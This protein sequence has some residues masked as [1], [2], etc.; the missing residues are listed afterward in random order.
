[1]GRIRGLDESA[2]HWAGLTGRAAAHRAAVSERHGHGTVLVLRA[3]GAAVLALALVFPWGPVAEADPPADPPTA[4]DAQAAR[5]AVDAGTLDV[6]QAESALEALRAELAAAQV[7][8][9][10]AAADYAEA[11]LAVE[12]AEREV[13][14]ARSVVEKAR[15][16]EAAARTSLAEVYR[17]SARDADLGPLGVALEADSVPDM[18]GR[19][20]AERAVQRKL[21]GALAA[22]QDAR[23]SSES[24]DARWTAAKKELAAAAGRAQTAFDA[25][26][27]AAADLEARTRAAEAER[28]ALVERLAQLRQT[29]VQIEREREA[30]RAAAAEAA[31]EAA[32]KAELE[33]QQEARDEARARVRADE[34]EREAPADSGG[35]GGSDDGDP[36]PS[37]SGPV[38]APEPAPAPKPA[39][40]PAPVGPPTSGVTVGS[41]GRGIG[42]VA[43][44]RTKIGAPYLLGAAGP[45]S[46]D[47]S[48]LTMMSWASQGVNITRT[49]R[50]QYLAVGKVDYGSLRAGDLIFYGSNPSDPASIYHV[51]M[52][53]GGGTMLEAT[54]PGH[55]LSESPLRL[56]NAMPYAGRP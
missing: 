12:L 37:G 30:A 4:A 16:G 42:A 45:S 49:S 36:P 50:S 15:K 6:Q 43:W 46:Y 39:P 52:Y 54:L 8:V 7:R 33:R 24:A 32:A 38:P 20:A 10:V 14:A 44:A 28:T 48:G 41:A 1:M 40:E 23:A 35:S 55:P 13:A 34:A 22:Y 26:Q 11:Q 5:D 17:A 2:G 9:Q 56:S 27:T 3:L 29:S 21:S 19:S 51:A 47:C 25:A 31:R 18:V 53:T